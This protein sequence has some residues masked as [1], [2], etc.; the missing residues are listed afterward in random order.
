MADTLGYLGY[1]GYLVQSSPVSLRGCF[2][3]KEKGGLCAKS[4]NHNH[5]FIRPPEHPVFGCCQ[6]S[7]VHIEM[8]DARSRDNADVVEQ[9]SSVG[10]YVL[11]LGR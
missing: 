1:L 10:K 11:Y 4:V 2:G 3:R 9:L 8:K 6:R 5:I 7:L